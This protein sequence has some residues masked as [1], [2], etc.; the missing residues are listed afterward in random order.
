[1]SSRSLSDIPCLKN[2]PSYENIGA[3]CLRVR[4]IYAE[5]KMAA[6]VVVNFI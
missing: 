4:E 3:I 6:V 1:M 2:D 5:N